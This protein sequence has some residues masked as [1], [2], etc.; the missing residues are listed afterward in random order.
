MSIIHIAA[1]CHKCDRTCKY[2]IVDNV[3]KRDVK[4]AERES[5]IKYLQEKDLWCYDNVDNDDCKMD[6][7]ENNNNQKN[8]L[9]PP[10]K[11]I[12]IKQFFKD[13][14][15]T[16]KECFQ[17]NNSIEKI[18]LEND[19]LSYY[20]SGN[21]NDLFNPFS[22]KELQSIKDYF[23]S[24]GDKYLSRKEVIEAASSSSNPSGI[25]GGTIAIIVTVIAVISV[26]GI[27]LFR[28]RRKNGSYSV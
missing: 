23:K 25:S 11:I 1:R 14:L 15:Q 27:V 8:K 16:I 19:E 18:E 3:T 9:S 4:Q 21:S 28:K 12:R 17:K 10:N 20:Y 6:D 26:I 5:F 13:K 2:E 24:S 7:T 22:N